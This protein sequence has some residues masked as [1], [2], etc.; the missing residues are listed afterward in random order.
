MTYLSPQLT[1]VLARVRDIESQLGIA[2]PAM[3][4]IPALPPETADGGSPQGPGLLPFSHVL[5]KV[6]GSLTGAV[7]GSQ[8]V[9]EPV[10]P[11]VAQ[12]R[13]LIQQSAARHGIDPK[14]VE[15]V[16][17][18]ESGYNP[19][20]ISGVGARGLMQLMPGT[21]AGLGVKDSFD[22][23]QNIEGGTK[24]LAGLIRRFGGN[25][26]HAVAA[27]NAGPSAVAKYNGVPPYRETQTY[28]N[29]VLDYQN[30]LV[31]SAT[32]P[33]FVVGQVKA[34]PM[35]SKGLQG[36]ERQASD[37]LPASSFVPLQ[38]F[39]MS[40]Q[41]TAA[42]SDGNLSGQMSHQTPRPFINGLPTIEPDLADT[43]AETA[44]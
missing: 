13:G 3:A 27:Y 30:N 8:P 14:L 31:A 22:P 44:S 28:V 37:V 35:I 32:P 15:A 17:K 16:V 7:N 4:P 1:S 19:R 38:A 42:F 24:Y 2:P 20:A 23:A 29:R 25:I 5:D 10:R 6:Q 34:F 26:R 12:I 18:A 36:I 41:S 39:P 43:L 21:A 40:A 9:S 33:P 11:Q